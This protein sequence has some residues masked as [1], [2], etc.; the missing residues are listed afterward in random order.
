MS[1]RVADSR[2]HNSLAQSLV[3]SSLPQRVLLGA[4]RAFST[5]RVTFPKRSCTS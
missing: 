4:R 1:S 5:C 3:S 2:L